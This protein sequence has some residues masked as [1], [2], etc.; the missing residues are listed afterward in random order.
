MSP[1]DAGDAARESLLAA[2][3]TIET[4]TRHYGQNHHATS[5]RAFIAS[6]VRSLDRLRAYVDAV[7]DE[8]QAAQDAAERIAGAGG[9]A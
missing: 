1:R 6:G 7:E 2:L 5:C 9:M 8:H 4:M 3:D